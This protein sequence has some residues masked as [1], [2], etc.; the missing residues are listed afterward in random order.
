MTTMYTN[1]TAS[2]LFSNYPKQIDH[3]NLWDNIAARYDLTVLE[4]LCSTDFS[5]DMGVGLVGASKI[6]HLMAITS[7]ML[8]DFSATGV[9]YKDSPAININ[10]VTY[11]KHGQPRL[12]FLQSGSILANQLVEFKPGLSIDQQIKFQPIIQMY[13]GSHKLIN[14]TNVMLKLLSNQFYI[15]GYSGGTYFSETIH[16]DFKDALEFIYV[17]RRNLLDTSSIDRLEESINFIDKAE[18]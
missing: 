3:K 15:E 5:P 10:G 2:A 16:K 14:E 6:A 7:N 1:S 12:Q 13:K 17:N 8:T 4:A 9:P 11:L 18:L